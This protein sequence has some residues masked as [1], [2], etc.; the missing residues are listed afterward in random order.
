MG[1][2]IRTPEQ[3]AFEIGETVNK[4]NQLIDDGLKSKLQIILQYDHEKYFLNE[5]SGI[6]RIKLN[7][8]KIQVLYYKGKHY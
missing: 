3:I 2:E 5:R 7:V 8:S 4:L 6:D 1:T